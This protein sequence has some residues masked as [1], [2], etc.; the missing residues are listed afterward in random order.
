FYDA[1]KGRFIVKPPTYLGPT[2]WHADGRFVLG[3]D[4]LGRDVAVRLL[5][6]GRNSRMI[7][8]G[9]ALICTLVA[10]TLALLAGYYR[11]SMDWVVSRFFDIIWAFAVLLLASATSRALGINGFPHFGIDIEPGSLWIPTLVISYVL[12]PYI[13]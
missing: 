11:G 7:G 2:W 8:I 10:L 1:D 5:Y 13:G 6:G 4:N 12:I 3:T 9:S